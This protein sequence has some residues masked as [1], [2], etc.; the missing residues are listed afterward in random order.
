M[1]K[2]D[3]QQTPKFERNSVAKVIPT[4]GLVASNVH[5]SDL[6]TAVVLDPK[7]K[8][9]KHLAKLAF[10][11]GTEGL[12]NKSALE[13]VPEEALNPEQKRIV[14]NIRRKHG[15]PDKL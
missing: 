5:A 15:L 14:T 2:R 13:V 4:Q 6:D 7:P 11:E 8:E 3:K 1:P 12:M 9:G 10:I